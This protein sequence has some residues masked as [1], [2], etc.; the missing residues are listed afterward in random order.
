MLLHAVGGGNIQLQGGGIYASTA[1]I[2][3]A[4]TKFQRNAAATKVSA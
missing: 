4:N 3:I 1:I 2:T